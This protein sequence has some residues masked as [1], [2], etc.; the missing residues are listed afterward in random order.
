MKIIPLVNDT[1]KYKAVFDDGKTTK[2]GASGYTDYI[3]SHEKDRRDRYRDRHA[4]DLLTH[5]PTKAGYLS[6]YLLW[7]SSTNLNKNIAEYKKRFHV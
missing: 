1:H 2:F 6:Y 3:M 4:K 5:D 7:G